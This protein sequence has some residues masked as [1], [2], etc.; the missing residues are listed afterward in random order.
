MLQCELHVAPRAD[1]SRVGIAATDPAARPPRKRRRDTPASS[2]SVS[3]TLKARGVV[4][5]VGAHAVEA[6][7]IAAPT[8][9]NVNLIAFVDSRTVAYQRP[10]CVRRN[11][12]P[13]GSPA[14]CLLFPTLSC[15]RSA[16]TSILAST[17]IAP[18]CLWETKNASMVSSSSLFD[19]PP[20][21]Y[22]TSTRG[23]ACRDA[24]RTRQHVH[25]V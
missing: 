25:S 3:R 19:G 20:V 4:E 11:I 16:C 2:A 12:T 5:T 8:T 6:R 21:R 9:T 14:D 10:L 17:G 13:T 18:R 22:A 15:F 1:T 24:R 23:G 7:R